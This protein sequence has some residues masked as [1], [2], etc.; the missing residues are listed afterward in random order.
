MEITEKR[1]SE[2]RHSFWAKQGG[3]AKGLTRPEFGSG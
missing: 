3:I 2:K 1:R